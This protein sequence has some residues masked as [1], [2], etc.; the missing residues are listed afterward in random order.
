MLLPPIVKNLS[1]IAYVLGSYGLG[2]RLLLAQSWWLNG[3][4]VI[5]LTHAL[6]IST[7]LTHEFI[8]GAIFKERSTN[9]FWGK[10]MTHINGGCYAT[11][12]DLV[13]HHFNHHVHHADFIALDSQTYFKT[14][15]SPVRWLFLALEWAYVPVFEFVLRFRIILAPFRQSQ[16]HHLRGRTA[17]LLVYRTGLFVGLG[18]LSLKA[19]LLYALS[20][21]CFVNVVR[22]ADAF[23]HTYDYVMVGQPM[24]KRDRAYE[25][26]N[27]FSNLVSTRYPWLNL[28][29]LN[30]GYH[31]A[32]H[33]DMRCP[34]HELPA[35]HQRLYGNDVNQLIPLNQLVFN[36][37]RFRLERLFTGQG[38]A[39][40]QAGV[41]LE[42]LIG[43]VGVSLLTPP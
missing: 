31:N 21:V 8:H 16:R 12:E 10:L 32:H 24:P 23:H 4:G 36:Y 39:V 17:A 6:V 5:V 29:Y 34:W 3:L 20:Y 19:L 35:L 15:P 28:L 38:D 33:H 42:T 9:E 41:S 22:F 25:S 14:L 43:G 18:W 7:L 13:Q 1:A 27:T 30:F 2:I 26:A 40:P 37:H 11:W